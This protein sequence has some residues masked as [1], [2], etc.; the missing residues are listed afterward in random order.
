MEIQT[1]A[2]AKALRP[3]LRPGIP[4]HQ[5]PCPISEE[6]WH[7]Y[8]EP[9]DQW[10]QAARVFAECAQRVSDKSTKIWLGDRPDPDQKQ[11]Q[12]VWTLNSL[13]ETSRSR[14]T[15][16]PWAVLKRKPHPTR[17]KT[18]PP[19]PSKSDPGRL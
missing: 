10:V 17:A 15:P 13:A 2:T 11:M 19:L 6:F 3:Y 1:Q 16:L 7:A 18:D 8:Q 12:A 9:L 14:N 5:Y 4:A